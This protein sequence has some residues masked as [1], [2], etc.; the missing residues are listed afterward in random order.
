MQSCILVLQTLQYIGCAR[1]TVMRGPFFSRVPFSILSTGGEDGFFPR[2]KWGGFLNDASCGTNGLKLQ[3]QKCYPPPHLLWILGNIF[4]RY[5]TWINI[6]NTKSAA[7]SG[8]NFEE[9]CLLSLLFTRMTPQPVRRPSL[10]DVVKPNVGT[11]Y[12]SPGRKSRSQGRLQGA[13]QNDDEIS[14]SWLLM[15]IW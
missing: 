1:K 13:Q 15:N 7:G 8:M 14:M 10:G 3:A 11:P 2:K 5:L 9:L 12:Q 6:I 4:Q